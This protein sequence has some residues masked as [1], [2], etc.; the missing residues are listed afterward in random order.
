MPSLFIL[1]VTLIET[2]L[3]RAKGMGREGKGGHEVRQK[4]RQLLRI[5]Y[6]GA[7]YQGTPHWLLRAHASVSSMRCRWASRTSRNRARY[8]GPSFDAPQASIVPLAWSLTLLDRHPTAQ[9]DIRRYRLSLFFYPSAWQTRHMLFIILLIFLPS[10][11]WVDIIFSGWINVGI[12]M[13]PG[14]MQ[15]VPSG[16]GSWSTFSARV[17]SSVG[18]RDRRRRAIAST[19]A[20]F[21]RQLVNRYLNR[22]ESRLGR[23]FTP[24]SV[25]FYNYLRSGEWQVARLFFPCHLT[26]GTSCMYIVLKKYKYIY[27]QTLSSHLVQF[28]T[29]ED[30]REF[31]ILVT[32]SPCST[33]CLVP[34]SRRIFPKIRWNFHHLQG[35]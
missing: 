13:Y 26:G 27:I 16:E 31:R 19:E 21:C 7:G 9:A 18:R 2:K 24:Q 8:G 1:N 23:W 29:T 3:E 33:L 35:S 5:Y 20:S 32:P 17:Y 34:E 25:F 4:A 22:A 15:L 30:S 28:I 10:D 12:V 6:A 14:C 11:I